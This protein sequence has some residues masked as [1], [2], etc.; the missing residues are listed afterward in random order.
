[1]SSYYPLIINYRARLPHLEQARLGMSLDPLG[2]TSGWAVYRGGWALHSGGV[3]GPFRATVSRLIH[4]GRQIDAETLQQ[5]LLLHQEFI[6]PCL[7]VV[8]YMSL[9][10]VQI[11]TLLQNKRDK[12]HKTYSKETKCILVTADSKDTSPFSA[13]IH[14][15]DVSAQINIQKS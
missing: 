4:Y 9:L 13:C 8:F 15:A 3:N 12:V 10:Q 7:H 14:F 6:Q 11:G 5:S 2:W 1:M